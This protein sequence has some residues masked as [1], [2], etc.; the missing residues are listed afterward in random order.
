MAMEPEPEQEFWEAETCS[1]CFPSASAKIPLDKQPRYPCLPTCSS[2][3]H[4]E[5]YREQ[6]SSFPFRNSQSPEKRR[7]PSIH[8]FPP[9]VPNSTDY[10]L[11]SSP[12]PSTMYDHHNIEQLKVP[13]G[14]FMSQGVISLK[15]PENNFATV[16]FIPPPKEK[17]DYN[18]NIIS[19]KTTPIPVCEDMLEQAKYTL[20]K[21][22]IHVIEII[23]RSDK[24]KDEVDIDHIDDIVDITNGIHQYHKRFQDIMM[25]TE[26]VTDSKY[27]FISDSNRT[28]YIPVPTAAGD[29]AH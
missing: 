10:P 7:S 15:E 1:G 20:S 22:K 11:R 26:R 8:K 2:Y 25:E 18:G 6:E 21:A 28:Q 12:S 24:T 3:W 13:A 16:V 14:C 27:H 19:G 29:N 5:F 4:Q 9:I 17:D 23:H